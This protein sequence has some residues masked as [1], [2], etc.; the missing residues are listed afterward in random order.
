MQR[1]KL[2]LLGILLIALGTCVWLDWAFT[3]LLT[4]VRSSS[5][6]GYLPPLTYLIWGGL[7]LTLLLS[8]RS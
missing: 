6:T 4:H 1:L 5:W 8:L 3:T 7:M 2:S